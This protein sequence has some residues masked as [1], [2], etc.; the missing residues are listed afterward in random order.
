MTFSNLMNLTS[1]LFYTSLTLTSAQI[2]AL[3]ATP[4]QM[5]AAPGAG[6]VIC[7]VGPL[8]AKFTYGGSNVF[9]A[10]ASQVIKLY[11]ATNNS[12]GSPISNAIIVSSA[13]TYSIVAAQAF[14]GAALA[15]LENQPIN[16]YNDVATEITGNAANNNTITLSA[17]YYIMTL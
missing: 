6:K 9:V 10:G 4:V 13:S 11:Y 1:S 8:Y 16:A 2:K 3:H 5:I 7:L 17:M 15:N 12:A 14:A